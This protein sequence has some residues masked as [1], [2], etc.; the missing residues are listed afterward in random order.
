PQA[1]RAG[2][3][4]PPQVQRRHHYIDVHALKAHA[5]KCGIETST[6]TSTQTAVSV[7]STSHVSGSVAGST[8][9][10]SSVPAASVGTAG[11]T[12]ATGGVLGTTATSHSAKARGGVLGALAIAGQ[13]T[14]PFTGF[15]LW[16]A[17]LIAAG[18]IVSGL[19]LARGARATA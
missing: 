11:S 13:S 17:V 6:S 5:K 7:G 15:P 1:L 19:G 14:L 10:G 4:Q 3:H 8:S 16:I 2:E 12:T 9:T 18:L